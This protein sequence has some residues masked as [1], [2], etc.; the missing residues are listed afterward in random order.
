MSRLIIGSSLASIV[1]LFGAASA[2]GRTFD[3]TY[4]ASVT[5]IPT[6]KATQVWEPI[7]PSN[8]DQAVTKLKE[9]LPASASVGVDPIYNNQIMHLV[10][11]PRPDG[12]LHL[13]VTYRVLRHEV[14][15]V[16][17]LA[18]PDDHRFRQADRLVPIGGKPQALL[19][20]KTLPGDQF[21]LA[22]TLYEIVDDHMRYRKDMPGW[23]R[24]DACWATD[25][26]FGNC[27]DFHSLF[28]SLARTEGIP[29]KFEIGFSIPANAKGG[30]VIGYHCWAKFKPA[31]RGWIPVD[32][33]EANQHPSQR[34]YF[35]GHLDANRVAF[36]TGRDVTLVPPQKGPAINFFV[37]PYVEVDGK[38]VAA[39]SIRLDCSYENVEAV[40]P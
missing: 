1:F 33:S 31:G 5:G 18:T 11:L 3:F 36:S 27:T 14:G 19:A 26:G 9:D 34:E 39:S 29:S 22:R 16:S 38:P 6:D 21:E 32:I 7:P 24:G 20:G 40:Q 17:S 15:E 10:A 28:I 23:G 4:S 37:R 25:S 30:A 12:S 8:A 35:F 2:A 13:S